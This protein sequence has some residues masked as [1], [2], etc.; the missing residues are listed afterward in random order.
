MLPVIAVA[1]PIAVKVV[2]SGAH[3]RPVDS[4]LLPAREK[5]NMN[6]EEGRRPAAEELEV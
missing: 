1:M 2:I 4:M 5:E 3:D 6:G